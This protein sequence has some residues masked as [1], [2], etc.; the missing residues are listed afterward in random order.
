M[1]RL[2]TWSVA[3]AVPLLCASF[4]AQQRSTDG[5]SG[6]TLHVQRPGTT[7]GE[8]TVAGLDKGAHISPQAAYSYWV[9]H[10]AA[11]RTRLPL[12]TTEAIRYQCP[13][14]CGWSTVFGGR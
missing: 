9:T 12:S 1:G 4:V 14:P 10:S 13:M 6:S 8:V 5:P 2:L 7:Q 11:L 3:G